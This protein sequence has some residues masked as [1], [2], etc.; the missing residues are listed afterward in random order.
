MVNASLESGGEPLVFSALAYERSPA[1]HV[2]A[3]VAPPT[4][5]HRAAA[6]GGGG[7]GVAAAEGRVLEALIFARE[8][9]E[10]VLSFEVV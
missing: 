1:G 10:R 8:S 4:R 2:A 5:Q 9:Q 6:I 3:L 7:E